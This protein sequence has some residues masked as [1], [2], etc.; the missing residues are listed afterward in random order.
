MHH[1]IFELEQGEREFGLLCYGGETVVCFP[2]PELAGQMTS[3][4]TARDLLAALGLEVSVADPDAEKWGRLV[5]ARRQ[6]GEDRPTGDV[7]RLRQGLFVR[8][9]S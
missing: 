9:R 6:G 2:P 5:L 3:A 1:Y 4:I 8:T 7:L